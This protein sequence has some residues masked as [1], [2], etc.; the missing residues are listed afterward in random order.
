MTV[1]VLDTPELAQKYDRLSD[2]QFEHGKLLIADLAIKPGEKVLDLGCG[3][4][5]LS[6]YVAQLVG[7]RGAVYGIDPLPLRIEVAKRRQRQHQN[8]H[9]A[10]ASASYLDL[11]ADNT[12]DVVYLNSVFH[13]LVDKSAA[14]QEIRRVLKPG[15][16][17]AISAASKEKPHTFQLLLAELWQ[18]EPFN[19]FQNPRSSDGLLRLDIEETQ[20]LLANHDFM[21]RSNEIKTFVDYFDEAH[22]VIDFSESSSFGNFLCNLPKAI[23]HQAQ[24]VLQLLLENY[25]TPWGIE[26]ARNLI[27]TIAVNH[28]T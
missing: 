2:K 3:T 12:F 27:F 20:V 9:F 10:V 5:R 22:A 23:K 13:W 8:L 11:Y 16:R 4:G 1:L 28:K 15:G 14:L 19:R 21:I 17:L 6:A 26:L 7:D 24:V 25:R 18:Q